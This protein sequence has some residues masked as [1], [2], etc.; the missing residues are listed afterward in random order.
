V[1]SKS[2]SQTSN[3][4][5]VKVASCELKSSKL[6]LTL[7]RG[8]RYPGLEAAAMRASLSSF[9]W[10]LPGQLGESKYIGSALA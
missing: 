1:D 10:L 5:S 3:G 2:Y 4:L 8:G 6:C 7:G 9:T